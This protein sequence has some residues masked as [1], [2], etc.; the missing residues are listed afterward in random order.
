MLR[1]FLA[2]GLLIIENAIPDDLIAS[3]NA[4]LDEAVGKEYRGYKYGSSDR[5]EHL[6]L[7]YEPF[8]KLW[9][10]P[11]HRRWTDVLFATTIRPCHTL[12]YLFGSQQDAHQDTIHL[13]TFPP[14]NM[15]GIW[16]ALQDIRP[17]SGELVY[18]EGSHREDRTYMAHL[19]V[20]KNLRPED[21]VGFHD[22]VLPRWQAIAE[23]YPAR[24]YR[25]KKGTI[26]IWHE[27]LLHG[28]S[29]RRDTSLERR[30]IVIHSFAEGAVTYSDSSGISAVGAPLSEVQER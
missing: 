29:V 26:A 22:K 18:Y 28:G 9:L 2:T 23:R 8:R 25:P 4:A 21:W 7:Q 12:V 5:I 24:T 27:N 13:T 30:S 19:G 11:A 17:D 10:H 20:G 6:H 15:C 1:S 14:G 3:A 16:I